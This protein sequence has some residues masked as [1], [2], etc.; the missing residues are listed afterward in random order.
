MIRVQ[1]TVT[2]LL[3]TVWC[4]VSHAQSPWIKKTVAYRVVDG[5]KVLADVYR[6]P[7]DKVVP[8]VVWIHGGALIM[9]HR[10]GVHGEVRKVAQD[11][12]WALVSIDYRLAPETKLPELISDVEAAFEWLNGKGAKEFKLDTKRIAVCGGSAGGYLTLVTGYRAKPRPKALVAL[13]GYGDLIED[14]YTKPSPHRRHNP[15]KIARDEAL[16]QTDG[17]VIS[18]ARERKGNGSLM[19]LH[20]RQNGTWPGEVSGFATADLAKRISPF[21]P[22]RNVTP[23]FPT[24]LMIHGTADTDVPFEESKM[25]AE[26]LKKH[27]VDHELIAI[28]DGEHGFGGG[29][30]KKIADAY[31]KMREFLVKQLGE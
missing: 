12:G 9:G 16:A 15:R 22:V 5:H 28:E 17:S 27:G 8:V 26:Q 13:Y 18:D 31:L 1:M 4:G 7:G 6:P 20:Y 29:D 10:E 30:P 19:Y 24:T 21:E 11:N 3:M 25:M 2:C 14:W 23:E